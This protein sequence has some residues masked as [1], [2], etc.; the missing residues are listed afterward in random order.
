MLQLKNEPPTQNLRETAKMT[1]NFYETPQGLLNS[2]KNPTIQCVFIT[3][4]F[5]NY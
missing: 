4:I 3:T 5:N 2:Q 1:E